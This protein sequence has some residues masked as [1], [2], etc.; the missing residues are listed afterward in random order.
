MSDGFEWET[1]EEGSLLDLLSIPTEQVQQ[2]L[3]TISCTDAQ[4]TALIDVYRTCHEFGLIES[5]DFDGGSLGTE[6]AAI[7]IERHPSPH[8]F[9]SQGTA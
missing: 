4:M 9:K 7:S 2:P 1:I 8:I 5:P 6:N 3:L